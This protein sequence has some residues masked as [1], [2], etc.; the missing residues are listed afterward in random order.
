MKKKIIGTMSFLF[1][2]FI[3]LPGPAYSDTWGFYNND[4]V[5]WLYLDLG[6]RQDVYGNVM[7][8]AKG[9]SIDFGVNLG[10]FFDEELMLTP[11]AGISPSWGM[12]YNPKFLDNLNKNIKSFSDS[13]PASPASFEPVTPSVN[14]EEYQ[15]LNDDIEYIKNGK[16]EDMLRVYYGLLFRYPNKYIPPIKLYRLMELSSFSRCS[17]GIVGG[18]GGCREASYGNLNRWGWGTEIMLF[19]GLQNDNGSPLS[20]GYVSLFAEMLDFENSDM[21][22]DYSNEY[23]KFKR[24]VNDSFFNEYKTEFTFGFKVGLN[25][26]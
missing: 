15:Y 9:L 13:P 11:F 3:F 16:V 7:F 18:Y 5:S 26:M 8:N 19:R 6:Y 21:E 1:I 2:F 4:S 20:L 22:S 12:K 25:F 24:Y 10:K 14:Q 17:E 23:S